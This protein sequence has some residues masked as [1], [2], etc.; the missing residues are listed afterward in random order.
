LAAAGLCLFATAFISGAA[1][2]DPSLQVVQNLSAV[3]LQSAAAQPQ[4]Q[5]SAPSAQGQAPQSA[6][7][8]GEAKHEEQTGTSNDR[9]FMV[10][11]NFLTISNA[12]QVP[13]LTAKQKFKVV[14]RSSFDYSEFPWYAAIAGI[15]QA[16]NSEPGFGQGFEGYGKRYGAA[17]ADGTIENFFVSA[18]LPS[19]LHTDPRF[20]Q[21]PDG[22]FT[23]RFWYAGTR[24]FVTRSDAGHPRFNVPE[25]LGSLMAAS[26]STYSYH[27]RSD[28]NLGNM[29][30]VWGSQLLY[31]TLTL[32]IKEFWPDVERK[33]MKHKANNPQANP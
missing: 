9:L 33:F 3:V 10:L 30:S 11:P 28:R 23:R 18:I 17:F 5:I 6:G 27:P 29:G 2:A 4:G 21:K 13:P 22:G 14:L 31:D 19:V 15:S 8:S 24:I 32:E 16:E 25:I 20:Y 12:A 1:A 7:Q 26:I